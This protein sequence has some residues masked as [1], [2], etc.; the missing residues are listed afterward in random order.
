MSDQDEKPTGP[1]VGEYKGNPVLTL[2]PGERFPF[3][4]GVGKAKLVL[5]HLDEIRSFVEKYG[6]KK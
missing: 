1:I 4:F 2:N 3:S 6:E 5:Q